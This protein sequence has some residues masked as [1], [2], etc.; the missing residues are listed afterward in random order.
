MVQPATG[1]SDGVFQVDRFVKGVIAKLVLGGIQAIPPR[2]P[3]VQRA[4]ARIVELFDGRV[5]ELQAAH[6]PKRAIRSWIEAG[7]EL[8][9]SATGGVENWERALRSAQLT[10]TT[11]GNPTYDLVTFTIDRARADSELGS[12]NP[13]TAQLVSDAADIIARG[14]AE[15]D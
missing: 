8:R 6:A 2:D 15:A 14:I 5:R 3:D 11:V 10:F 12:L 1:E 7:N 13:E 4:F 9:L